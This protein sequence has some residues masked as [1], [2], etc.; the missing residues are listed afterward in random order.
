MHNR[1]DG[2]L[3]ANVAEAVENVD[4]LDLVGEL[5]TTLSHINEMLNSIEKRATRDGIRMTEMMMRDGSM[6]AQPWI[7]A[8]AN[9]LLA[10][11]TLRGSEPQQQKREIRQTI[12]FEDVTLFLVSD[13]QGMLHYRGTHRLLG[14]INVFCGS[15]NRRWS[16]AD[17][18]GW[19]SGTY[20]SVEEAVRSAVNQRESGHR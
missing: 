13:D 7:T 20:P 14:T 3:Y 6:V 8:K 10:L 11:A 17:G 18:G 19:F 15:D 4:G 1:A 2:K 12:P 9:V 5:T 16:I